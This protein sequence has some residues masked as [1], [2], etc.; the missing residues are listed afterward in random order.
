MRS[1]KTHLLLSIA[2]LAVAPTM[3][4]TAKTPAR[5]LSR[6]ELRICMD[7]DAALRQREDALA[8]A[9]DEHNAESE[10]LAEEARAL[11]VLL[12]ALDTS[13]DFAVN[14]Y[15]KRNDARNQ[16]V[17]KANQRADALGHASAELQAA[18]ADYIAECTARPFLKADE[19]AILREGVQGRRPLGSKSDRPTAPRSTKS[20]DA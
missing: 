12:R 14:A 19:E 8:R 5:L 20:S 4:Q 7:R 17:E 13:D 3:A 18:E 9:H 11:S 1:S 2:L 16:K 10:A 6:A 15:N